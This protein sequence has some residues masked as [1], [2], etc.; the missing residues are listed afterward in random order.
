MTEKKTGLR[1]LTLISSSFLNNWCFSLF[2]IFFLS[3]VKFTADSIIYLQSL[4]PLLYFSVPFS[5][6][7]ERLNP[8]LFFVLGFYSASPTLL[9]YIYTCRRVCVDLMS[10]PNATVL[11]V[12]A[13]MRCALRAEISRSSR[14]VH[15]LGWIEHLRADLNL[16][17]ETVLPSSFSLL[18][19]RVLSGSSFWLSITGLN[20]SLTHSLNIH[21]GW[22]LDLARFSLSLSILLINIKT[23]KLRSPGS[24]RWWW[25]LICVSRNQGPTHI[26][27]WLCA[28]E[29]KKPGDATWTW[30]KQVTSLLMAT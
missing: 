7:L 27:M 21:A 24:R 9:R 28:C 12:C 11:C 17:L 30:I 13:S 14:G 4:S 23:T 26:Y 8:A 1:A 22:F 10:I 15:T 19:W 25:N 18:D 3:W 6:P 2:S 29:W 16:N 20:H 5:L